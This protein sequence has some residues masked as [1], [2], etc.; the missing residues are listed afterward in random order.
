MLNE[1]RDSDDRANGIVL[2]CQL[3]PHTDDVAVTYE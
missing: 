2:A 3:L 1:M